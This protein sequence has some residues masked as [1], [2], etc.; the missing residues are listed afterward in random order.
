MTETVAEEKPTVEEPSQVKDSS[1]NKEITPNSL[2][3]SPNS[4]EASTNLEGKEQAVSNVAPGKSGTASVWVNLD[5]LKVFK[6]AVKLQGTTSLSDELNQFFEKRTAEIKGIVPNSDLTGVEAQASR[7]LAYEASKKRVFELGMELQKMI[8]FLKEQHRWTDLLGVFCQYVDYNKTFDSPQISYGSGYG[9]GEQSHDA[10]CI[11]FI[12][13]ASDREGDFRREVARFLMRNK[14]Y[15]FVYDWV[16]FV[17]KLAER[18]ML[19]KRMLQYQV[20]RLTP[21]QLSQMQEEERHREE[22]RLKE[23]AE[24]KAEEERK[25]EEALKRRQEAQKRIQESSGQNQTNTLSDDDDEEFHDEDPEE[26]SEEEEEDSPE[27]D[28]DLEGQ[29]VTE[30]GKK[31]PE[32]CRAIVPV[33]ESYE[34]V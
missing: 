15:G 5:K 30:D 22:N 33:A 28:D 29:T 13:G 12:E 1:E 17:E 25:K 10:Y 34:R 27:E 3:N 4:A 7:L 9:S 18:R 31:P 19:S 32:E 24:A 26:D 2:P 8:K 21:E 23:L 20:D 16:G 14:D 11:R 6:A